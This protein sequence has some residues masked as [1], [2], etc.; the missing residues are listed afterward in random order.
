MASTQETATSI[1]KNDRVGRTRY[2][3]AYKDEVV[4]AYRQSNMSAAAFAEHCG[5]K[6]PT[7]ASWVAKSRRVGRDRGDQADDASGQRFLLAEIGSHLDA[8][9]KVELP[10]GTM[11]NVSSSQQIGLLAELLKA[12]R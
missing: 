3:Q 7:F 6:Y 12:L 2:S 1:I 11:V 4:A 9:L 5:V 10:N 8:P